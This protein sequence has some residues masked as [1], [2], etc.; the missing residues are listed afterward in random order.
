M[1]P[2]GVIAKNQDHKEKISY[3]LESIY[4]Y[5]LT[6]PLLIAAILFGLDQWSGTLSPALKVAITVKPLNSGHHLFSE[7]VS[8]IERCPLW[9]ASR[10]KNLTVAGD[11]LF[12]EKVSAIERCPL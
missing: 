7:K 8:A 4:C 5:S 9:R 10:Y 1:L 3:R 12:L 2:N 11:D 6:L